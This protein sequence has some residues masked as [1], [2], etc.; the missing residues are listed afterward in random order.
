MSA[1]ANVLHLP[2]ARPRTR[3]DCREGQRPCPWRSC[4]W[5]SGAIHGRF[6][7][8]APGKCALDL[9]EQGPATLEEIAEFLDTSREYVR[10]IMLRAT[11]RL[12]VAQSLSAYR[13]HAPPAREHALG[14]GSDEPARGAR[15]PD[16]GRGN[17]F[18]MEPAWL[19]VADAR[20]ED[21]S[22]AK[23]VYSIYE[24]EADG[25]RLRAPCWRDIACMREVGHEGECAVHA[26]IAAE[27]RARPL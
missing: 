2:I 23:A 9:I 4:E 19:H 7:H 25:R 12:H 1:V 16:D 24:A 6:A 10:Q 20:V 22:Y 3:D 13:D 17:G 27:R 5:N 26:E 14:G 15:K 11:R 21:E 8:P 18:E